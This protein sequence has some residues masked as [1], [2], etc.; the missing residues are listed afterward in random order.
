VALDALAVIGGA[1]VARAEGVLQP[2]ETQVRASDA[3]AGRAVCVACGEQIAASFP[4]LMAVEGVRVGSRVTL[5]CQEC[6]M[7]MD[8]EIVA[9]T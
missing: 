7:P 5:R 8:W 2:H 4:N 6:G 9:E 1:R 3:R